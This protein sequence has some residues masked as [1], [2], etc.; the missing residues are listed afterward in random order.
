MVQDETKADH[1][2]LPEKPLLLLPRRL[3]LTC[4]E[5]ELSTAFSQYD[6]S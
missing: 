3:G 6:L 1:P 5:N 2:G 4:R